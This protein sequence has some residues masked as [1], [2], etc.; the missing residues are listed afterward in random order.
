VRRAQATHG[1]VCSAPGATIP[2]AFQWAAAAAAVQA[3]ARARRAAAADP[4]RAAA[5]RELAA[6]TT[7]IMGANS[8][9]LRPEAVDRF[10]QILV[11]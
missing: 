9:R 4:A 2:Q 6:P 5:P 8:G 3:V 11:R 7:T 1:A 10:T